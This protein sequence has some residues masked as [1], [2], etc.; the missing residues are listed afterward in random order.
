MENDH[1]K[2]FIYSQQEQI[3]KVAAIATLYKH[4]LEIDYK[5]S[6]ILAEY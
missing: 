3:L 2:L 4:I 6:E 5:T 1:I